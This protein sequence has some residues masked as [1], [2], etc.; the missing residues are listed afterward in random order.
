MVISIKWGSV[1]NHPSP[2]FKD[3]RDVLNALRAASHWSLKIV[4]CGLVLAQCMRAGSWGV[5]GVVAAAGFPAA[6]AICWDLPVVIRSI[7]EVL[8]S[9]L[10]R[11][12]EFLSGQSR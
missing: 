12:F 11:V 8:K 9:I 5:V 1:P 7:G 4:L 2:L 6:T 10:D 3:W